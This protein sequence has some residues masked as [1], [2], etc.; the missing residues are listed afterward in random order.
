MKIFEFDY[1][2]D[3]PHITPEEESATSDWVNKTSRY[4]DD[5]IILED[6]LKAL[7]WYE[8]DRKSVV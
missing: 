3:V 2:F 6:N 8:V 4:F 7:G 5:R 1:E